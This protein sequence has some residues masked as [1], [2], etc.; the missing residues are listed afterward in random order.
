MR[1]KL[2]SSA[3]QEIDHDLAFFGA[4]R[5]AL[6]AWMRPEDRNDIEIYAT[7]VAAFQ[8]W[9][10]M[11]T[12]WRTGGLGGEVGLDYAVA[13]GI[14]DRMQVDQHD[15]LELLDQLRLIESGYLSQVKKKKPRNPKGKV[16]Q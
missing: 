13:F 4:G 11:W 1:R 16:R 3:P 7:N 2:P 8:L 15:Q 10:R 14:M 12:Q 5:D 9:E 6:P